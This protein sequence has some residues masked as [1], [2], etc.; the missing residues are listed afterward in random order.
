[1]NKEDLQKGWAPIMIRLST[2]LELEQIMKDNNLR[3]VSKA[4]DFILE[5]YKK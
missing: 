2:K 1:M 4:I 3:S 5:N